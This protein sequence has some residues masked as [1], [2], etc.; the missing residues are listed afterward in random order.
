MPTESYRSYAVSPEK[1]SR[2]VWVRGNLTATEHLAGCLRCGVIVHIEFLWRL[3]ILKKWEKSIAW[4]LVGSYKRYTIEGCASFN[5][6]E[7]KVIW[8]VCWLLWVHN[9]TCSAREP[10]I[11]EVAQEP[12]LWITQCFHD[13]VFHALTEDH[14][15]GSWQYWRSFGQSQMRYLRLQR[16]KVSW[17][18][19]LF[20]ALGLQPQPLPMHQTLHYRPRMP[21]A[22]YDISKQILVLLAV[23]TTSQPIPSEVT[24]SI[25]HHHQQIGFA[26]GHTIA[27]LMALSLCQF[28]W[29]VF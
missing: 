19:S 26:S 14:G 28:P 8:K 13:N 1:R 27:L 20:T 4:M 15:I 18:T 10:A 6:W 29:S 12:K 25:Y 16:R 5:T 22:I 3:A 21:S 11:I 7:R 23:K 17:N 24:H 9:T 2:E